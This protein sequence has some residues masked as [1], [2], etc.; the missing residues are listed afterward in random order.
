MEPVRLASLRSRRRPKRKGLTLPTDAETVTTS[1]SPYSLAKNQMAAWF[2]VFGSF[3]FLT[4][5]TGQAAALSSTALTL[6]GLSGAT[7]LLAVASDKRK[8][9]ER[10]TLTAEEAAL[11]KEL[12]DQGGVN[13]QV[14]AA[15][16]GSDDA[17]R[18]SAA[19][20]AKVQ[21]LAAVTA[22]LQQGQ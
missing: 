7:G 4:V 20:G 10:E 3:I 17:T 22:R 12:N 19:I 16:P 21:R 2:V 8:A 13:D 18:L 1:A 11:K 5:T 9:S 6:I 14:T 15:A